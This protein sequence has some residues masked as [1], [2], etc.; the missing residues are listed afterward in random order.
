MCLSSSQPSLLSTCCTPSTLKSRSQVLVD[1]LLET[2]PNTQTFPSYTTPN[3][4]SFLLGPPLAALLIGLVLILPTEAGAVFVFT[5]VRFPG[6]TQ[7]VCRELRETSVSEFPRECT[8]LTRAQ[9]YPEC[10]ACF[11]LTRPLQSQF[12]HMGQAPEG[13]HNSQG[14]SVSGC[15][16]VTSVYKE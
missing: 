14:P 4:D 3:F 7:F 1:S 15:D 2:P 8:L 13:C 11:R 10:E 12:P 5:A 9:P 6:L 16:R